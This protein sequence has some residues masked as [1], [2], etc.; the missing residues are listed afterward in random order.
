MI[1]DEIDSGVSGLVAHS[2][3]KKIK[4]ISQ[5]HQVLCIT[6]LPQVAASGDHHLKIIKKIDNDRTYS[7]AYQL[8][9]NE[10]I[11]EIAKM[12]SDGIITEASKKYGRRIN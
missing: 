2:I 12:I 8:N 11:E 5:K 1:F 7:K 6:H 9:R 10:R 3:A 4:T